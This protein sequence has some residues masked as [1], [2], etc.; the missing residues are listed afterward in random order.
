MGADPTK[1]AFTVSGAQP[2]VLGVTVEPAG[3]S[4]TPTNA[5]IASGTFAD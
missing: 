5:M 1:V 2:S 3:G 4:T